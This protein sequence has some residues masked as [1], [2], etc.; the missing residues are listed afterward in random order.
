MTNKKDIA[1]KMESKS[2]THS[3]CGKCNRFGH[4]HDKCTASADKKAQKIARL[5][6]N[7]PEGSALRPWSYDKRKYL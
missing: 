7:A 5:V 4:T 6:Q 3:R 2:Y 1:S